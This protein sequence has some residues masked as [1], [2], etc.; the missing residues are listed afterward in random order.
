MTDRT[1]EEQREWVRDMSDRASTLYWNSTRSVNSI[2]D[3][4]G[5]S[6]GRLYD[7]IRPLGSGE[8]CPNCQSELIFENRTAQEH[9]DQACPVCDTDDAPVVPI[10]SA[11]EPA[12]PSAHAA[13]PSDSTDA[14]EF[15]PFSSETKRT[16]AGFVV[17]TVAGLLLGK[18]LR[19]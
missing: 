15:P 14:E 8:T 1:E 6:K 18:Y 9:H 5:L 16:V 11:A 12:V 13:D 3:D 10:R 17:G 4:L 2:A 7:L 19:S